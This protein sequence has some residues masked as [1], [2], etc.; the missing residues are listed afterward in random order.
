VIEV[1]GFWVLSLLACG[2]AL[3]VL[4][5]RDVLHSALWLLGTVTGLAGLHVLLGA[6]YVGLAQL[7]LGLGWVLALILIARMVVSRDPLVAT[8]RSRTRDL[9]LGVV[10]GPSVLAVIGYAVLGARWQRPGQAPPPPETAELGLALTGPAVLP[11]FL[12][13]LALLAVTVGAVSL[14]RPPEAADD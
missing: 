14:A 3:L 9:F 12:V 10:V 6:E 2:C 5:A 13:G 4:L 1:V 11:L 8:A 7:L